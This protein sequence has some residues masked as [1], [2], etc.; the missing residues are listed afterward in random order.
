MP[1]TKKQVLEQLAAAGTAQNRKVY[2]R[3]GVTGDM[4]GVSYAVLGKLQKQIKM[5]HALA[6]QLWATGNHD[7]RILATKIADPPRMKARSLDAWAKELDNYVLTDALSDLACQSRVA[8][9]CLETWSSRGGEWIPSAGWSVLARCLLA[10]D[11]FTADFLAKKL[12]TIE[13]TIHASPNRVRYA[14]NGALIAIGTAGSGFEKKAIATA[15][16]IGKVKV[17]HG[18]TGCKTPEAVTY[19]PKAAA[20]YR[21]RKR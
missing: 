3:H 8:K 1:P 11:K 17:D 4:Y 21:Q 18:E 19:I 15:R 10:G 9:R 16:R 7:A 20:R 13:A 14:M 6:E 12:S 2:R 5:D